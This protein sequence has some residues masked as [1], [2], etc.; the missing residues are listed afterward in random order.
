MGGDRGQATL[1]PQGENKR[2]RKL[3][4]IEVRGTFKQALEE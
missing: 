3:L 1:G 4:R 2:N